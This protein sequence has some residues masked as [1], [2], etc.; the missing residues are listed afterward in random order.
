MPINQERWRAVG[1]QPLT[2]DQ[3][4]AFSFDDAHLFQ[5]GFRQAIGN[6]GRRL[7]HI[8]RML[9]LGTDAGD[10]QKGQQLLQMFALMLGR[11]A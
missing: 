7:P 10:A 11:I 9:W 3:R 4:M 6:P 1:V 5:P 8:F 2:I